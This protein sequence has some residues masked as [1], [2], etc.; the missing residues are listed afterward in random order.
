MF[1]A[2]DWAAL[3]G[4]ILGFTICLLS[5]RRLRKGVKDNFWT[6]DELEPL[7]RRLNGSWISVL[8]WL[9]IGALTVSIF[10]QRFHG[11]VGLYA[12]LGIPSVAFERIRNV[13]KAGVN[14]GTSSKRTWISAPLSSEHWGEPRRS[15]DWLSR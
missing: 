5:V 11:Y 6:K 3:V 7:L 14:S 1:S 10:G 12:M 4:A 2:S 9:S 15:D 8:G 13:L